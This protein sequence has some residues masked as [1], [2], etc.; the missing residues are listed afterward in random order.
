MMNVIGQDI[1]MIGWKP[2]TCECY[3]VETIVN[4]AIAYGYP[5]QLCARHTNNDPRL[6]HDVVVEENSRDE[7]T[8]NYIAQNFPQLLSSNPVNGKPYAD[9]PDGTPQYLTVTSSYDMQGVLTVN[10]QGVD[11]T[12]QEWADTTF[13][14]GKVIINNS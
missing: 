2:A 3:F 5:T 12:V 4:G 11:D 8:K 13:G 6:L 14:A 7:S 1:G 10:I 9:L